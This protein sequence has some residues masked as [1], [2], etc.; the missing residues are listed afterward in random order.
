MSPFE[1]CKTFTGHMSVLG[2]RVGMQHAHMHSYAE[3]LDPTALTPKK[4]Q[5]V[6][7]ES[8]GQGRIPQKPGSP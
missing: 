4:V 3:W 6:L 5:V 1:R 8:L 7:F 2:Q